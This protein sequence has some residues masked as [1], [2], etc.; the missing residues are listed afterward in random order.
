MTSRYELAYLSQPPNY[1]LAGDGKWKKPPT[2]SKIPK[3]LAWPMAVNWLNLPSRV[4]ACPF[5]PK[6]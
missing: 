4:S 2:E 6:I 1:I 3:L 5:G